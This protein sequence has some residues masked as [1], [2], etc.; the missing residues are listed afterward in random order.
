[1][2]FVSFCRVQSGRRSS[3]HWEMN[4]RHSLLE[5]HV[6]LLCMPG[7]YQSFVDRF[8]SGHAKGEYIRID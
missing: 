2:L 6:R 8:H 7:S 4:E 1:M 5:N 3:S